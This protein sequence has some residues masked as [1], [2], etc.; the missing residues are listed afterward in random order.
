MPGN[1]I[2]NLVA[3]PPQSTVV[4]EYQAVYRTAKAYQSEAEL[5]PAFIVA[6]RVTCV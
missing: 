6:V 3:A 2:Y 4:T 5:D 1:N